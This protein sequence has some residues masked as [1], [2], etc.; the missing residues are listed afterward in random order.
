MDIFRYYFYIRTIVDMVG[1]FLALVELTVT[2][3]RLNFLIEA[4]ILPDSSGVSSGFYATMPSHQS[5]IMKEPDSTSD[6]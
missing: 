4:E 2:T 3:E 5:I 6:S 1:T